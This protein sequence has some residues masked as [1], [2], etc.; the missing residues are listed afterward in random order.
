V[1]YENV[2][3]EVCGKTLERIQ[4]LESPCPACGAFGLHA[5]PSVSPWRSLESDPPEPPTEATNHALLVRK[6]SRG[7]T[8][9]RHR[10]LVPYNDRDNGGVLRWFESHLDYVLEELIESGY[11]EW[12]E[13]AE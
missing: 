9:D 8:D 10:L 1:K 3:V 6:M 5:C 11:T 12:M 2:T 13:V 7:L 4:E